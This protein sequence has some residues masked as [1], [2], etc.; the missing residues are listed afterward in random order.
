MVAT[1]EDPN[2][3][4]ENK[5]TSIPL[6]IDDSKALDQFNIS[7]FSARQ[8]ELTRKKVAEAR[9]KNS[10]KGEIRT[11]VRNIYNASDR[12]DALCKCICALEVRIKFEQFIFTLCHKNIFKLLPQVS[13][14]DQ[15]LGL[16]AELAE[17]KARQAAGLTDEL[18]PGMRGAGGGMLEE[19]YGEME[20]DY[21]D[22]G[23]DDGLD[24][25]GLE[26][27]KRRR[28]RKAATAAMK[29]DERRWRTMNAA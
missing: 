6:V 17:L 9:A 11:V 19:D 18:P 27:K 28:K 10:F 3:K 26:K 1:V 15:V 5:T 13:L 24:D 16:E 22:D 7:T 23:G 4:S 25:S 8:A 14:E 21:G 29:E 20:Y 12:G 2:A